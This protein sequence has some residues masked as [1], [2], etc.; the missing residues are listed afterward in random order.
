[1]EEARRYWQARTAQFGFQPRILRRQL[2]PPEEYAEPLSAPLTPHNVISLGLRLAPCYFR[3]P[4]GAFRFATQLFSGKSYDEAV[5]EQKANFDSWRREGQ[6]QR[7]EGQPDFVVWGRIAVHK[8]AV[9]KS[10]PKKRQPQTGKH[11]YQKRKTH[12]MGEGVRREK[13]C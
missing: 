13:A 4:T 12:S 7:I 10:T 5:A 6:V 8:D 2:E 9:P 3:L 1:M 11:R